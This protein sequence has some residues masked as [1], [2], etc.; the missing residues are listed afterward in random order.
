MGHRPGYRALVWRTL[1]ALLFAALLCAFIFRTNLQAQQPRLGGAPSGPGLPQDLLVTVVVS[2]REIS[3]LPIQ[4]S[5]FVKLNSD[6]SGVHLTAPTM[7]ASSATFPSVRAG[8]YEIE[9]NSEG[10][11]TASEHAS[12]MPNLSSYNVY[13]Y[14]SKIGEPDTAG[15]PKK[16]QMNPRVQSEMD[17]GL[18]KMRHQQFDVARAHFEKAAKIAPTNADVQYLLGMLEYYQQHYDLAE[19]KLKTAVSMDPSHERALAT[20]GEIE[21]R[22]DQPT[23]AAKTLEQA[24]QVNGADWHVHYL[25]AFAYGQ[26][27]EYDKAVQHAQKAAELGGKTHAA[28]AR[29]LL[30]KLLVS[31]SK[32]SEA[33]AAFNDIVRDFPDDPAAKEAKAAL[34]AIHKTEATAA[35][36][37]ATSSTVGPSGLSAAEPAPQPVPATPAVV[38]PWAPEDVDSKE[39]VVAPDVSCSET[40]VLQRT[41]ART[42]KQMGNFEKFLATEHI[43]HQEIDAYGD[44]GPVKARDFTYLV[45]ISR[46]KK[47]GLYL[48]E[49]RDGGENLQSFPTSLASGLSAWV[50]SCSARNTKMTST[51]SVR[52]SASGA[53][54]RHGNY[55]SSKRKTCPRAS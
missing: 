9:V 35:A 45:F 19:T 43:E 23:V 16:S 3:G 15:G 34:A 7:D 21:L 17:K 5:A 46:P 36:V 33:T 30:A 42:T 14:M 13:V 22:N 2:V 49:E 8:E 31:Q 27:K 55:A 39:Y 41:E 29:V 4:G 52:D 51:T 54:R 47:G 25:L 11:K 48:E 24:Y 40:D 50:Y 20:L 6:F 38:R 28:Q 44:P 1:H 32:I 53:V 37:S 18:D 12:I 26:Q 10:Y